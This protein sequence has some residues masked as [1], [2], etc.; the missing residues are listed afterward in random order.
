[1]AVQQSGSTATLAYGLESTFGTAPANLQLMQYVNFTLTP[2]PE[3]I[4]DPSRNPQRAASYVRRGNSSSTGNLEVVFR[5]DV[6][7]DHLELALNGSWASNVLKQGATRKSMTYEQGFPDLEAGAAYR[8]FSGVVANSMQVSLTTNELARITFALQGSTDTPFSGTQ[9]DATPTA[10][11]KKN[12]YYHLGGS[13]NENGSAIAYFSTLEFTLSN[14]VEGVAALGTD[15]F[16]HITPGT[17]TLTGTATALFEST[18]IYNRF[19]NDTESSISFTLVEGTES[20]T[21]LIPKI[22]YTGA[23]IQVN[24]DQG[25]LVEMQFEAFLEDTENTLLKVTR[26]A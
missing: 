25:L 22:K 17:A 20:H 4:R 13:F 9:L 11:V 7:D 6:L 18:A 10:I 1:M 16:R 3:V 26:S 8:T 24:T 2:T 21:F 14:N 23:G 19:K 15:G 5:P 12:G